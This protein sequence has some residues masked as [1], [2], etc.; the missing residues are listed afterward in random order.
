MCLNQIVL[1]Y[2]S[3]PPSL[4]APGEERRSHHL[5]WTRT[6]GL[7]PHPQ[8]EAPQ[9]WLLAMVWNHPEYYSF[10]PSSLPPRFLPPTLSILSPSPDCLPFSKPVGSE[11]VCQLFGTGSHCNMHRFWHSCPYHRTHG[12]MGWRQQDLCSW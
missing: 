5:P 9:G 1:V 8:H 7:L 10:P 6:A 4:T 3:L 2:P 11:G 12:D